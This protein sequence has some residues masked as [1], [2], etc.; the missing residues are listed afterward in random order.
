ME[1]VSAEPGKR[2]PRDERSVWAYGAPVVVFG[3][4]TTFEQV[5][6]SGMYPAFYVVKIATVTAT[7]VYFRGP[8]GDIRPSLAVVPLAAVIALVVL[9]E[10]LLIDKLVPY[11]HLGSRVAYNPLVSIEG[12][13]LRWTFLIA[14]FYGLVLVVPVMEELFWR[15]FLLRYA[16]TADFTSLA[17]GQFSAMAFWIMVVLSAAAHPEW[18]VAAIASAMFA[19]LLHRTRSLFAVIVSHAVANG[20]LGGYILATGEWHYW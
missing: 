9:A 14:R 8:L 17:V 4:L 2:S 20:A 11:P 5:L 6:P 3:V 15:S 18:L 16:T 12:V 10:W 13:W 7:L 1:S 19:W